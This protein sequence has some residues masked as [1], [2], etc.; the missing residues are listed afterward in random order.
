MIYACPAREFA[1]D[2]HLM[3]LQ[4]LLRFSAPLANFQGTP[5]FVICMYPFKFHTYITT[6]FR[7]QAQIIQ[8]RNTTESYHNA[9]HTEKIPT[10]LS[11][12]HIYFNLIS[13]LI[14]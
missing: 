10:I 12:I 7:Q 9:S 5:Q 1:A 11:L 6:L 2:T 3:K 13:T 8:E 4:S 14:I